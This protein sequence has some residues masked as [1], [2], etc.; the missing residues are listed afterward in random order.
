M[1]WTYTPGRPCQV[2]KLRKIQ[3]HAGIFSSDLGDQALKARVGAEHVAGEIG[4]G[5]LRPCARSPRCRA[6]FRIERMDGLG[7]VGRGGADDGRSSSLRPYQARRSTAPPSVLP[8]ISPTGGDRRR[9][10]APIRQ[11]AISQVE[12]REGADVEHQH[13]RDRKLDALSRSP[14]DRTRAA[15]TAIASPRMATISPICSRVTISGGQTMT[16]SPCDAAGA[17]GGNRRS[18]R[19][20]RRGRARAGRS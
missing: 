15:A 1:S 19:A 10:A 2:E 9:F 17:R 13:H 16:Q 7:V 6:S 14:A 4:G 11:R 12:R 8:D 20:H 18:A 5:A 3:A